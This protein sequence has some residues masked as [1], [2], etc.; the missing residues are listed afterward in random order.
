V[1]ASWLMLLRTRR[2]IKR[3]TSGL[4]RVNDLDV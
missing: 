2:W 1:V 3:K 4:K